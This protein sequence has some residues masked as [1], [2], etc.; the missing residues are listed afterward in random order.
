MPEL[1]AHLR[2]LRVELADIMASALA[3]DG[4]WH[5][6]MPLLAE[7]EVAVQAVEAVMEERTEPAQTHDNASSRATENAL[8]RP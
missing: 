4:D 5:V 7:V 1:I 3:A 6:W 8:E 2:A